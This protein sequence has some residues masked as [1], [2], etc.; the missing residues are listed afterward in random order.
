M[1]VRIS[2]SVRV[3]VRFSVRIRFGV[4]SFHLV[5]HRDPLAVVHRK[6]LRAYLR[7]PR[8]VELHDDVEAR[9]GHLAYLDVLVLQQVEQVNDELCLLQQ[10][11]ARLVVVQQLVEGVADLEHDLVVLLLLSD[12][13]VERREH[14][15]LGEARRAV[16]VRADRADDDDGLEEDV[17]LGEA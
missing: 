12:E 4:G 14:A 15:R 1:R 11:A 17:V 2:A 10:H 5:D 16:L 7:R 6:L 13:R 8:R 3:R 9:V